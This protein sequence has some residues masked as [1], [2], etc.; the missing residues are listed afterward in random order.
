[1]SYD[2]EIRIEIV[3]LHSP[4]ESKIWEF[5]D[6]LRIPWRTSLAELERLFGLKHKNHSGYVAWPGSLD[7]LSA[8]PSSVQAEVWNNP[9]KD[10]PPERWAIEFLTGD[11]GRSFSNLS[12][13]ITQDLG[14]G[15][16]SEL[17]NAKE[18]NWTYG[19]ASVRLIFCFD[20]GSGQPP[21][22]TMYISAGY[23]RPATEEFEETVESASLTELIPVKGLKIFPVLNESAV[24]AVEFRYLSPNPF[25]GGKYLMGLS[26]DRKALVLA[27]EFVG[28]LIPVSRLEYL[29]TVTSVERGFSEY[30]VFGRL[31]GADQSVYSRDGQVLL[32]RA[33]DLE[34]ARKTALRFSKLTGSKIVEEIQN[35][36]Y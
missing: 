31:G 19:R 21:S 9:R 2:V 23:I 33:E 14:T 20:H 25:P 10:L 7:M 35:N 6:W 26:K 17:S 8:D 12:V 30:Y 36:Q 27:H 29:A 32:A 24:Y 18:V 34:L 1:M 28:A 4:V 11:V 3:N 16:A 13:R 5:L 22:L 15:E